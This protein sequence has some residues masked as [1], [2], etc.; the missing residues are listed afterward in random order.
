MAQE[1]TQVPRSALDLEP[2]ASSPAAA[3]RH[4][5][6]AAT[7]VGA[8][9]DALESAAL[10]VSELVTN[11]VLH[12]R[13]PLRLL[14]SA[15]DG[16]LLVEVS[17]SSPDLPRSTTLSTAGG[18]GLRLLD[19]LAERWGTRVHDEGTGK[20][21]W[22]QVP[23]HADS[24]SEDLDRL[25]EQWSEVALALSLDLE[26][27]DDFA[28][29]EGTSATAPQPPRAD[30]GGTVRLEGVEA[31]VWLRAQVQLQDLVR[32]LA[33]L[34]LSGEQTAECAELFARLTSTHERLQV[35]Y[36]AVLR[37]LNS[38]A[39][40]AL[41]RG[42]QQVDLS[43]DLGPAAAAAADLRAFGRALHAAE[44]RCAAGNT[45][46]ASGNDAAVRAMRSSLG[47]AVLR[48]LD[49]MSS[50]GSSRLP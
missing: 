27:F 35:K 40:Q 2:H 47:A 25:E 43:V 39:L 21:V 48:Q 24:G 31:R 45:L 38:R 50:A 41:E 30:P 5:R 23:L 16:S 37:D 15:R 34:V 19:R 32:E 33:L 1:P 49:V 20:T 42:D 18:R 13:T 14:V 9:D 44:R 17:D 10:L 46:L 8:G 22:F 29:Q 4:V 12:A 36:D 3:R 26:D 6:S 11:V 28:E 7:A